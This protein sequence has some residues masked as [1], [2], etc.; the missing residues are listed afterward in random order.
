MA[1][2]EIQNEPLAVRQ[3]ALKDPEFRRRILSGEP[4]QPRNRDAVRFMNNYEEIYVMDDSLSYEPSKEDSIARRAITAGVS[5]LEIMLDVMA[6]GTPLLV[7]FGGYSNNLEAQRELI[8]NPH[9]VFGLSDGGAH[10][11]VLVDASVPTYMLSYFARDRERGPTIPLPLV[12]HKMTQDTARTY[13]LLDRGVVAEGYRA[14]L[15]IIDF[16]ALKLHP[17]EMVYDLPGDGK[18]LI[19]RSDGYRY[20]MCAGEVTYQD[21]RHTGAMPGRLIRGG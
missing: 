3:A 5:P 7:F 8:E 19:Q 11:G 21:G 18:R 17:P 13:G 10:C 15:N 16:E 9:S 6:E 20:T 1:Y 14:D 4:R 2:R 12:V